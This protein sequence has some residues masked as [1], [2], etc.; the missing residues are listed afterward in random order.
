MND[1]TIVYDQL[2]K[3]KNNHLNAASN[4]NHWFHKHNS[5]IMCNDVITKNKLGFCS[6]KNS[7]YFVDIQNSTYR[8]IYN[9]HHGM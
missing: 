8:I 2:V 9:G 6:L 7:M 1:R 5:K 3:L 4:F